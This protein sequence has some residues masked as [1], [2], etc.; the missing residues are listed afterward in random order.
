MSITQGIR[1]ATNRETPSQRSMCTAAR[2]PRSGPCAPPGP[3]SCTTTRPSSGRRRRAAI[4]RAENRLWQICHNRSKASPATR[5]ARRL[6][7]PV[8]DY[9]R[10]SAPAG[11]VL[12]D[13]EDAGA[14]AAGD[15]PV[16]GVGRSRIHPRRERRCP[17]PPAWPSSP[18]TAI[19]P[20]ASPCKSRGSTPARWR[21]HHHPSPRASM[22]PGAAR[23]STRTRSRTR[24]IIA[25]V[26]HRPR[27]RYR[28]SGYRTDPGAIDNA[29]D[30]SSL[31]STPPPRPAALEPR[32]RRR[33]RPAP[34]PASRSAAGDRTASGVE[35][36]SATPPC[37]A[38]GP[39]AV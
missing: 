24:P 22:P 28:P 17:R 8:V 15:N 26:L 4:A 31:R 7:C 30:A 13:W 12:S 10:T 38:G 19:P 9:A 34:T 32:P 14:R 2:P 3:G 1:P 35:A 23:R 33:C 37:G 29:V 20:A 21:G 11:E 27:R 36:G 18:C 16:D 5:P 25:E 39:A 6:V